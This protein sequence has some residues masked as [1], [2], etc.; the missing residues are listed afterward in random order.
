MVS[1]LLWLFDG[2][3][4]V[5][6]AKAF[7]I[8]LYSCHSWLVKEMLGM[9]LSCLE[10][11]KNSCKSLITL[12]VVVGLGLTSA[13]AQASA[14]T[15]LG[16]A[17]LLGWAATGG[18]F[19]IAD[20]DAKR[21]IPLPTERRSPHGESVLGQW[22]DYAL[23]EMTPNRNWDMA[24]S[25]GSDEPTSFDVS[26][27]T[28]SFALSLELESDELLTLRIEQSRVSET[29]WLRHGH[30][31]LSLAATP[32][33]GIERSVFSSTMAWSFGENSSW[34]VSAVVASQQIQQFGFGGQRDYDPFS[35][36][37]AIP[38]DTVQ[39]A[40]IR[41]GV[42]S[43]LNP[44]FGIS[45]GY[46][47]RI[48][49]DAIKGYHGVFQEPADFDIPAHA[50]LE[51]TIKPSASSTI[52]LDVQRVM[53]GELDTFTSYQ[54]PDRILSLLGDGGSPDFSWGD[55][56]VYNAG[57]EVV[58]ER[59]LALRVSYGTGNQ[60]TPSSAVL[61]QSLAP[62]YAKYNM[63]VGV[64][65]KTEDRGRF[66]LSVRYAP[67]GRL[68]AVGYDGSTTDEVELEATW[69]WDF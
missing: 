7:D 28:P 50:N 18:Y 29:P 20:G 65:K 41:L 40:G 13:S 52:F 4:R 37:S 2:P 17:S 53:Y 58:S 9:P 48:D 69:L 55:R 34:G 63:S 14:V 12:G 25:F 43:D 6:E 64:T 49:M 19:R 38:S 24:V 67:P 57:I 33:T 60:P 39:G 56:T 36:S 3:Q 30:D 22:R 42:H 8:M 10:M 5:E 21:L 1:A 45:A 66:G 61:Y 15:T 59:N 16:S 35:T 32:G 51:L 44:T 31:N 11:V 68:Y 27:L 23:R 62:D 54:M 47:S 46:Q 26:A